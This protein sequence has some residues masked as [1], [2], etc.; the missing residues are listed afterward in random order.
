MVAAAEHYGA[1]QAPD[2]GWPATFLVIAFMRS[3]SIATVLLA[4]AAAAMAGTLVLS[5]KPHVAQRFATWGHVWEDVRFIS[6][7][8]L[9]AYPDGETIPPGRGPAPRL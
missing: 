2:G 9:R 1:A 5:I 6:C 8:D 7:R 4:V 3:G